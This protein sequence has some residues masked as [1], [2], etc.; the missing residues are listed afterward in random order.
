MD[1]R[2][3][4]QEVVFVMREDDV[5]DHPL[6]PD[7][8]DLLELAS[9]RSKDETKGREANLRPAFIVICKLS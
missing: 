2:L 3:A 9:S 4:A 8:K 1:T 6:L 7:T 5:V